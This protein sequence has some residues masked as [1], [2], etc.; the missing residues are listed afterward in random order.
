MSLKS[1]RRERFKEVKIALI[2]CFYLSAFSACGAHFCI[3]AAKQ[4]QQMFYSPAF[5]CMRE[6]FVDKRAESVSQSRLRQRDKVTQE[7]GQGAR[8]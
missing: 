2:T 7:N 8:V 1:L 4:C 3:L 6:R 5:Q